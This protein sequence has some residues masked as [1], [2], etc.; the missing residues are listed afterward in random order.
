MNSKKHFKKDWSSLCAEVGP[1][2]GV[3]P[4]RYFKTGFRKKAGHKDD[5]LCKQVERALSLALQGEARR[6]E[7]QKLDVLRVEPA[8]DSAHLL[9]VVTATHSEISAR[10][11]LV[12]LGQAYGWLRCQVASAIHRKKVPEL[13]FRF[14]EGGEERR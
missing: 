11:A 6:E 1:D 8:P 3:D 10:E 9:V 4:C 14:V 7:L 13:T 12:L 2:D 5:Q